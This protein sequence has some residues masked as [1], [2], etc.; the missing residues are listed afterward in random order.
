MPQLMFHILFLSIV[1]SCTST[2]K[3][4]ELAS[5]QAPELSHQEAVFRKSKLSQIHYRLEFDFTKLSEQFVGST[6]IDFKYNPKGEDLRVDF[7]GGEI[8]STK[9]NNKKIKLKYNGHFFL[10]P[11]DHLKEG[12][13]VI[14]ISYKKNF[15]KDGSGLYKFVDPVDKRVYLYSDLQPFDA[16]KIFPMFDQPNLKASYEMRVTARHDWH[17]VTS[18]LEEKKVKTKENTTWIFPTSE[19]F[20]TYIWSLHAGPYYVFTDKKAKYPSRVF[21][22]QSLHQ[23]VV[24]EDWFTFTRQ[25][26]EFFNQYFGYEYPYK[27]YD[28]LIVPDFNAG[29][30]E[31]V[32]AVTFTERLVSRGTKTEKERRRLA[33]IILHEMAHMWFGNLVTMDW[34][35]DLW[36]NESFAT[37]LASLAMSRNTEFKDVTWRDFRGTKRWALWEDQMVTTHPIEAKV[38]NTTQ[39]FAN[40]D[41]ITYGKGASSLKQIHYALGDEGF[42][43]GVEHYFKTYAHKNTKLKD[44]IRSLE[45]GSGQEL[46]NWQEKWLQTTGVNTI[47]AQFTCVAGKINSFSI[48]QSDDNKET[49][50][51]P[52]SFKIA[53]VDKHYKVSKQVKITLN[54]K[55]KEVKELHGSDCPKVVY[56]NFEDMDYMMVKLDSTSLKNLEEN[57]HRVSDVFLRQLLWESLWN[58][59]YYDRYKPQRYAELIQTKFLPFEREPIIVRNV[60]DTVHGRWANSISLMFY[61]NTEDYRNREDIFKFKKELEQ[62]LW[63]NLVTAKPGSELQKIYYSS[64]VKMA[65]SPEGLQK[66]LKL[67]QGKVSLKGLEIDQ[68]KSWGLL[69]S[70]SRYQYEG[71]AS[72][73]EQELKKDNTSSG[74]KMYIAAKAI[75]PNFETKKK[76]IKEIQKED[77]EYSLS[78]LKAAIY[79]LFPKEQ[80]KLRKGYDSFFKDLK[81]INQTKDVLYGK[82]FAELAPLDCQ[83]SSIADIG[84]FLKGNKLSEPIEKKL[85]IIKQENERCLKVAN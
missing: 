31:N 38:P 61:F 39:A 84:K 47:A 78:E 41:G 25:G 63:K 77:S 32:A 18:V 74:K 36:L 64:Y 55:S 35:D 28:Q 1:L 10:I 45:K 71:V 49:I 85:K 83:Q 7:H 2:V 56:P 19:K 60:L 53:L 59:V 4:H 72:L 66:I 68:D 11:N 67:Y 8:L 81:K 5:T 69:I 57:I 17:V 29:A 76:W 30:M 16:N 48:T 21:V 40:F 73:L 26:F 27:K 52:H 65:F 14:Q 6:E 3:R 70:L 51:R 80:Y 79:N 43:K 23:H 44:F 58:M 46:K 50:I 13:N 20:S 42:Q 12:K 15:S 33:N 9:I 75:E 62:N 82:L 34:W 24:I 54:S 22:R 37:Y